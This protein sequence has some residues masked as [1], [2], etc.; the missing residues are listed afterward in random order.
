[1]TFKGGMDRT[2]ALPPIDSTVS[3]GVEQPSSSTSNEHAGGMTN[4]ACGEACSSSEVLDVVAS[5]EAQDNIIIEEPPPHP[6]IRPGAFL[7]RHAAN[8]PIDGAISIDESHDNNNMSAAADVPMIVA[9]L[10]PDETDIEA[11]LTVMNVD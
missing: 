3:T 8:V 4:R 1:M 11:R 6:K 5:V 7:V 2:P 9:H 10:A